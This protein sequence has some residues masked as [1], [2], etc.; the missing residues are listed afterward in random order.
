MPIGGIAV[1]VFFPHVKTPLAPLK[2]VLPRRPVA[3]LEGTSDT[4]E[5]RIAGSVAGRAVFVWVDVRSKH[6]SAAERRAA[7]EA[8]AG[9]RFG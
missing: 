4:P 6:P 3:E 7:Q 2:L 9:I 1:T 5:Y 8:L